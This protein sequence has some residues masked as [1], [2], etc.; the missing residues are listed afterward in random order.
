MSA[1]FDLKAWLDKH[2]V[3][4]LSGEPPLELHS[5]LQNSAPGAQAPDAVLVWALSKTGDAWA[6]ALRRVLERPGFSF[7]FL[8][9]PQAVQVSP[10]QRIVIFGGDGAPFIGKNGMAMA[11]LYRGCDD[12]ISLILEVG[13]R[14]PRSE[15][16]A[17]AVR[18]FFALFDKVE[19]AELLARYRPLFG[20]A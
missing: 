6:P 3:P 11:R 19:P 4:L 2:V 7:D 5:V 14:F 12:G 15:D 8:R 20:A 18:A 16:A 10:D 13:Y 1:T 9:A 17:Q